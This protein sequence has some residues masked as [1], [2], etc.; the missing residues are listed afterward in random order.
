MIDDLKKCN[1]VVVVVPIKNESGNIP[2]I[3]RIFNLVNRENTILFFS[4][5]GS[6]D[7]SFE[8]AKRMT[9]KYANVHVIKQQGFGKL[10]AVITIAKIHPNSLL[11]IWD[12]DHT[13]SYEDLCKCIDASENGKYFVYGN[14]LVKKPITKAMPFSNFIANVVFAKVFSYIF[15]EGISDALCGVKILENEILVKIEKNEGQLNDS[16]GDISYFLAAKILNFPFKEI[17]VGYRPR[18]YGTS[19]MSR[20]S[21]AWELL[22]DSYKSYREVKKSKRF[23][24]TI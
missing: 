8:T 14:R 9:E 10:N 6:C 20:W 15:G 23:R 4:E 18:I 17:N 22:Q 12:G 16:F 24:K 7:D 21:F 19:N 2:E 5:G 1:S 13:I 11:A 3:A